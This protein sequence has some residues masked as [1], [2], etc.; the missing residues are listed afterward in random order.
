MTRLDQLAAV[1]ADTR[2]PVVL[3]DGGSGAGKTSFAGDLAAV[4]P[5]G[6]RVVSLDALYPG[7]DGLAA[8]SDAVAATVLRPDDPG[9]VRWDWE[10]GRPAGWV[11]LDPD[12]PLL[13]E[14]CGALTAANR[15]L[16]TAGIWLQAN[17]QVRH[18][19]ALARDG[20]VFAAHWDRWAAQE[21]RHW[22]RHRPR[23]L[24][25]WLVTAADSA[26]GWRIGHNGGGADALTP[27]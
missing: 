1:L 21:H 2:R 17:P 6:V 22:R 18:A 20:A 4:W 12:E 3:V 19:R 11:P 27:P 15:V 14:G 26:P 13:V 7:W 24:A 10:A 9:Y 25:D 23:E 16:A 8:G 5:G